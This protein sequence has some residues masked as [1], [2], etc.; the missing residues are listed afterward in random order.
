M[1]MQDEGKEVENPPKYLSVFLAFR[2]A[3]KKE[4]TKRGTEK[5]E[6]KEEKEEEKKELKAIPG[7][8]QKRKQP[9][10]KRKG[11]GPKRQRKK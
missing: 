7:E 3:L 9:E 4:R 5:K 1:K 6:E 8:S 2:G 11:P 10:K